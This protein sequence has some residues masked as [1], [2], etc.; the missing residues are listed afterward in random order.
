DVEAG[1][2][3]P[4]ASLRWQ[5]EN[6][7]YPYTIRSAALSAR[8]RPGG[9]T[10]GRGRIA[11]LV[12][13]AGVPVD[14]RLVLPAGTVP[15]RWSLAALRAAGSALVIPGQ[16]EVRLDAQRLELSPAFRARMEALFP[17]DPLPDIFTP[18]PGIAAA[19]AVLPLQVRVHYSA[20]PLA[21]AAAAAAGLALAALAAA[22]FYRRPRRVRVTVDGEP[23]TIHARSGATYPIHDRA[24]D[25]VARLETT[26]FGHRLRV[27]R[28][29]A[30]VLLGP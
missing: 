5:L 10:L 30:S 7:A 9:V 28:E 11:G 21:F 18:P 12:P 25:E 20:A 19:T 6:T 26:L 15:P 8:A 24:G 27:L 1:A 13:G 23:R 2:R 29:G 16:V 3:A 14:A 17:G 22:Q 4:A